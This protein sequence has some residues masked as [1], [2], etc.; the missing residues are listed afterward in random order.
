MMKC[1][2]LLLL[3]PT[4]S[5]ACEG[6][7]FESLK[8]IPIVK[9]GDVKLLKD[10]G[11]LP[12]SIN[13]N[14]YKNLDLRAV[15]DKGPVKVGVQF[16]KKEKIIMILNMESSNMSVNVGRGF[17]KTLDKSIKNGA[18]TLRLS[19]QYGSSKKCVQKVRL[20]SGD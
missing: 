12:K 9:D 4:L 2:K 11:T 14:S 17:A 3:I 8:E 6:I 1:L 10:W 7:K 16:L 19:A 5:F 18:D 13:E 15:V 20:W